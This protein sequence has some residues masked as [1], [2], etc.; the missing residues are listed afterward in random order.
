MT[1][2]EYVAFYDPEN[3]DSFGNTL[4]IELIQASELYDC[5]DALDGN[6]NFPKN[7]SST[8][9]AHAQW[10]ESLVTN[11]PPAN[12]T[13]FPKSLTLKDWNLDSFN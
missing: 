3:Y 6:P 10:G 7:C 1:E 11:N 2:S 4:N 5:P 12:S 8:Y 9:L 13:V